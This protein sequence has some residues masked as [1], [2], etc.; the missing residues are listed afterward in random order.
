MVLSVRL[1]LT[2]SATS[3]LCVYQ[4]RHESMYW[5]GVRESNPITYFQRVVSAPIDL[6]PIYSGGQDSTRSCTFI[7]M[8]DALFLLR[9]LT[10]LKHIP[11]PRSPT[12]TWTTGISPAFL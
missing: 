5:Q 1:E 11:L 8:R 7:L 10:V 3:T 12:D 6:P 4:L 2:L 9:Y